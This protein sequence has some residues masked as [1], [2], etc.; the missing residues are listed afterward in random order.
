MNPDRGAGALSGCTL[1]LL[2][3][4]G[5]LSS[6]SGLLFV[7]GEEYEVEQSKGIDIEDKE[8]IVAFIVILSIT[9]V[10]YSVRRA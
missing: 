4:A 1:R 5:S 10:A 7:H 9:F 6:F 2:S 3:A 8:S